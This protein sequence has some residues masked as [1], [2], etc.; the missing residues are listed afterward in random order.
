[1]RADAE[2]DVVFVREHTILLS[3][4][5]EAF[6]RDWR[7][8]V[9]V[10]CRLLVPSAVRRSGGYVSY[11]P[12]VAHLRALAASDRHVAL[13]ET[14]AEEVARVALDDPRVR[15]VEVTVAKRDVFPDADAVGVTIVMERGGA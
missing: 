12:V 8:R 3:I 14:L 13:I 15:A 11:A 2:H 9:S 10:S 1:M 4:G 6:E 7:Q 5:V